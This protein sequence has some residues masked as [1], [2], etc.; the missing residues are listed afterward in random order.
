MGTGSPF[1]FVSLILPFIRFYKENPVKRAV[2]LCACAL[3]F[4]TSFGCAGTGEVLNLHVQ[5]SGLAME[6]VSEPPVGLRIAILAFEDLR[7]ERGR[8]GTRIDLWGAEQEFQLAGGEVGQVTATVMRGLLKQSGWQVELVK[9]DESETE[10]DVVLTGKIEELIV[11]A[12]G[13]LFRT[14]I[15]VRSKTSVEVFNKSDK[16]TVR[17][18]VSGESSDE[19]FWFKPQ[20]AQDLLNEALTDSFTRFIARTKVEGNLLRLK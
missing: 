4:A 2:L 3:V 6:E 12:E 9:T 7:S 16:S 20:H 18:T 11:D 10:A 19:F 5:A 13:K 17:M 1:D 14:K 8:L 15:D